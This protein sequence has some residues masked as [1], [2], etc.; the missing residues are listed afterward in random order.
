MLQISKRVEYGLL[1]ALHLSGAPEGQKVR[2][3]EIALLEQIP[4]DYLAKIL[5]SL[6]D[7]DIVISERGP[8]GGFRLSRSPSLI[9][10]LQVV[11]AVDGP[12]AIAACSEQGDGCEA[13]SHCLISPV[14]RDGEAAL[15]AVLGQR[16][17]RP[18]IS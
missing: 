7:A 1:A 13:T 4:R 5:R 3:D 12:I 16:T 15:R 17:L 9:T 8:R 2:L 10:Y 18:T 11:E 14:W 6:V